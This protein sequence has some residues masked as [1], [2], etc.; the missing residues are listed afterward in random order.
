MPTVHLMPILRAIGTQSVRGLFQ[1][2]GVAKSSVFR[3]A[4]I[5]AIQSFYR[6]V[7][8]YRSDLGFP[9]T[10]VIFT[11]NS[12][13]QHFAGGKI[14]F[15]NVT[16]KG[17][18]ETAVRVRFVGFHCIQES[19]HDQLSP[20]DEPYFIIGVAGSNGSNTVRFGPYENVRTGTNGFEATLLAD[21]FNGKLIVPPIVIGVVA[22]EHDEGTPEEAETKVRD[23]F[24][25]IEE[26]FDQA[27]ATFAGAPADNHV[28]PEWARE[29]VIGWAPEIVAAIFGLGDDHIG[30]VPLIMFDFNPGLER[31]VTPSQIA[32]HGQNPYNTAIVVDGGG[33]GK[34][35]LRF[36]VQIA[37]INIDL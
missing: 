6:D 24:E 1:S 20:A 5:S 19:D 35:E 28:L 12:G 29:I 2:T 25:A 8:K 32:L 4:Q 10:D 22:W 18:K 37:E 17:K 34:Y 36:Q 7:G 23:V 26:K 21:P 13:V 33:E 11:N 15:L 9:L 27:V 14:Q 31:W 3:Q 16:P 30:S